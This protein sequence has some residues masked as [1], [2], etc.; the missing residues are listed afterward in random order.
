MA[1]R[2]S[3]G[4][5]H[6]LGGKGQLCAAGGL[7][8]PRAAIAVEE[9]AIPRTR[10]DAA[11]I[12]AIAAAL[13]PAALA[14]AAPSAPI[15]ERKMDAAAANRA[16]PAAPEIKAER[17][18]AD[19]RQRQAHAQGQGDIAGKCGG[20]LNQL[21]MRQFHGPGILVASLGEG[22]TTVGQ[23]GRAR[24]EFAVCLEEQQHIRPAKA[25]QRARRRSFCGGRMCPGLSADVLPDAGYAAHCGG[26]AGRPQ[27][28]GGIGDQ[29]SEF[30]KQRKPA[31]Q[32]LTPAREGSARRAGEPVVR[33]LLGIPRPPVP[34]TGRAPRRTAWSSGAGRRRRQ[35]LQSRAAAALRPGRR[36]SPQRSIGLPSRHPGAR[37]QPAVYR[38]PQVLV[39]RGCRSCRRCGPLQGGS[40]DVQHYH[41]HPSSRTANRRPPAVGHNATADWRRPTMARFSV[42]D[43]LTLRRSYLASA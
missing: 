10:C 29:L 12:R 5:R 42:V 27:H 28:A 34:R 4:C 41:R 3:P 25:R 9:A 22:V 6:V 16:A 19:R 33:R 1:A 20:L 14:D 18:C 8:I 36:L 23:H 15:T 39:A 37:A 21:P 13:V 35:V 2:Q 40:V 11:A 30:R 31:R 7:T 32:R 38:F 17:P 26:V 43:N 24:H